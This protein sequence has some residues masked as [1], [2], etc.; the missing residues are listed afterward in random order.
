MGGLMLAYGFCLVF[1]VGGLVLLAVKR[2]NLLI[3]V[4]SAFMTLVAFAQIRWGYY[5]TINVALLSAYFMFWA[6]NYLKETLRVTAVAAAFFAVVLLPGFDSMTSLASVGNHITDD[7][8]DSLVW[9]RDNTPEPLP[10]GVYITD[11]ND[12]V[13]DY[14]VLSWWDYGHWITRVARR[15]PLGSP[16]YQIA[17]HMGAF[18]AGQTPE[19]GE[20]AIEGL[21][22]K[23]VMLDNLTVGP[24]FHAVVSY[25]NRWRKYKGF[26]P[27]SDS[28]QTI[29][30]SS[31]AVRLW[32]N[33]MPGYELVYET[34]SVKVFERVGD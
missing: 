19:E 14:S 7:W 16:A 9:V 1:A 24:K 17:D 30:T 3:L 5:W 33:R 11:G 13:A 10:D 34:A 4:W 15:V 28:L 32:E 31:N 27:Y 25:A 2:D 23:Y 20:Q 18:L 6:V 8:Y 21:G 22:V 26:E 12:C 29:Q